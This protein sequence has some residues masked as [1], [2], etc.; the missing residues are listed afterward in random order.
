MAQSGSAAR[1]YAE[2]MYDLA[3]EEHAVEAYRASLDGL[4]VLAAGR[5]LGREVDATTHQA[6]IE[7]S[8]DEAGTELGRLS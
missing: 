2:A 6:L 7:R 8:L 3:L 1:R 5:I 4:A